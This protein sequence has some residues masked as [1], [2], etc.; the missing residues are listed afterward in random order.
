MKK[1]S[2]TS[3]FSP[4]LL[5]K[6]LA[7]STLAVSYAVSATAVVN[8]NPTQAQVEAAQKAWC[9]ALVQISQTHSKDGVAKAKELANSVLDQA[10]GYNMGAVLFK[11]TLTF[12]EQ[13]FRTTKAGALSYFVGDDKAFPNDSGFALKGW[14]KCEVKNSAIHINGDVALTQGHV[15]M[16]DKEGKVTTVD[17]TWGFKLD[18]QGALRI[19]LHHSSLPFSPTK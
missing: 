9:G 8:T 7:A 2:A 16:T 10:Y 4:S 11:P 15:S 6:V 18:D 12:G 13:T 3:I 14:E 17:K 19:V 1:T 5:A